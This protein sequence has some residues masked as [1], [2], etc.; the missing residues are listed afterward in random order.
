M[1][2]AYGKAARVATR[3][4]AW[5]I[6]ALDGTKA[7]ENY[8]SIFKLL[9]ENGAKLDLKDK[10]GRDVKALLIRFTPFKLEELNAKI[11]A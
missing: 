5:W 7:I 1:S 4:D 10:Q 9:L 8:K 2:R 11:A 3:R 6:K